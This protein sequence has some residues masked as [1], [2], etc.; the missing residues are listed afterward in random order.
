MP[1]PEPRDERIGFQAG[2][3]D[4]GR[5]RR[6]P[7]IGL[8]FMVA[9]LSTA[10]DTPRP[11]TLGFI[12]GLSGRVTDLGSNARNGM[13]LAV[14]EVNARG[15][16]DGVPVQTL[17]RDDKQ[18]PDTARGAVRELID[19]RVDAIIGP[20]TS[21]IAMAVLDL[22]NQSRTLMIGVSTTTNEL[23]D[24]DDHFIRVLSPTAHY[25][26]KFAR[27][28][29]GQQGIRTYAVI[30][31]TV[32]HSYTES[33][34]GDFESRFSALGGQQVAKVSFASGNDLALQQAAT[35][36][37]RKPA[38]IYILV[39]HSVDAALLAKLIREAR[40]EARLATA[41]W[42]A[43]E[44]LI[45]LGGRHVEGALVQQYLD[46][47]SQDPDFIAFRDRFHER[48]GQEPGF[49]GMLSYNATNI[50][51]EALRNKAA[52]ETAR[53]YILRRR[54]F[55]TIQGPTRLNQF[56]DGLTSIYVAEIRDARFHVLTRM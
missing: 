43:T 53:D 25:T 39:T 29:H 21:V 8:L 52:G 28:L 19:A 32:N 1:V 55:A 22:V 3:G 13:L 7:L 51:L 27:Y 37:V 35:E 44:R 42:A 47:D 10:C 9:L 45:E 54:E 18:D 12:G 16:I 38:D 24:R 14:E 40:P 34:V 50:A 48:F 36:L 56:G 46:R 5:P 30:Y 2:S 6:V 20:V 31:D 11:V 49:A 23:S 15:G 4:R 33:W 17:I 26:D 41:E